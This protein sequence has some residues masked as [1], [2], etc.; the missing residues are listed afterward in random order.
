MRARLFQNTR[1]FDLTTRQ[2]EVLRLVAEGRT[3]G[4][5]ADLLGISLDGVKYHIREILGKTGTTSREEA[6]E[7]WRA[8]R[9]ERWH[10]PAWA[11]ALAGSGAAAVVALVVI[12]AVGS[13]QGASNSDRED[14][15]RAALP[16][17]TSAPVTL[18][19]CD[20]ADV[21]YALTQRPA[22][23]VVEYT[24]RASA[25]RPCRLAATVFFTVTD[26]TGASLAIK[27]NR[28]PVAFD[29]PLPTNE[30]VA[31]AYW[32][33][34]CKGE[35]LPAIQ[36]ETP[37]GT[38]REPAAAVPDCDTTFADDSRLGYNAPTFPPKRPA[39]PPLPA[40]FVED[41]RKSPTVWVYED[42]TETSRDCSKLI[43]DI[44]PVSVAGKVRARAVEC[45]SP[46][47]IVLA[48]DSS[49]TSYLARVTVRGF[50]KAMDVDPATLDGTCESLRPYLVLAS[51]PEEA[52]V[53]NGWCDAVPLARGEVSADPIVILSW[54]DRSQYGT[55][56]LP[57][58]SVPCTTFLSITPVAG[59]EP[60][61]PVRLACTLY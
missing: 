51:E 17:V 58:A 2:E 39:P 5:I 57:P 28:L 55:G 60:T 6:A 37:S 13:G 54:L 23:T 33:N 44:V 11:L 38:L 45:D 56:D 30:I 10:V 40:G 14:D 16:T 53:W 21:T 46:D 12:V 34:W 3:N 8:E 32:G 48:M 42:S 47:G 22:A 61:Q 43:P 31:A 19:D 49:G 36:I 52:A 29:A 20:P 4:E 25:S 50:T 15:E 18:A 7:R 41:P 1:R 59:K 35:V 27:A 9:R 24:V 26:T